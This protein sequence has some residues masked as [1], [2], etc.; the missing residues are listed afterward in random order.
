MLFA[1]IADE[2]DRRV[3]EPDEPGRDRL[4]PHR[5]RRGHHR[6][7]RRAAARRG[8]RGARA[9]TLDAGGAR[10]ASSRTRAS[11][12]AAP[13][14]SARS[15]SPSSTCRSSRC[16]ASRGSCSTRWRMT[17]LFALARRVH[18][19]A[20]GGAGAGELLPAAARRASTRPGCMRKA[21]AATS[22]CSR[23]VLA[24]RVDHARRR[25]RR[26]GARRR[27][28]SPG[29]APS[30]SRSSTKAI[31]SSRRGACPASR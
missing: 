5:R 24:R 25:A 19:L 16:A 17:V 10:R 2:R 4:R 3:R 30:S 9:G 14:S 20:D 31:C 21:H 8:A 6:R 29:S 28:R 7:E 11:R 27:P 13:A 12:C 22:R 18:P 15:S 1:V 26:A 23:R